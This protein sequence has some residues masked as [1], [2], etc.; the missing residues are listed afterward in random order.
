MLGFLRYF[1]HSAQVTRNA[2]EILNPAKRRVFC[3]QDFPKPSEPLTCHADEGPIQ[4]LD[5]DR[6]FLVFGST[7]PIAPSWEC[8]VSRFNSAGFGLLYP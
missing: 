5:I 4:G 7:T 1:P 2:H 8:C 6:G 3:V